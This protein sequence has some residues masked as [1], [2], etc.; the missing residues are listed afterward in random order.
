MKKLLVHILA[1]ALCLPAFALAED[2]VTVADGATLTVNGS[3]S[4]PLQADYA[5]IS[6]GVSTKAAT[7]EEASQENSSPSSQSLPG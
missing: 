7:V 6:I 1:L 4:V 3:A 5:R 2:G